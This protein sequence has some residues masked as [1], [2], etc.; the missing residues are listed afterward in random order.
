MHT[1]A[2]Q[3]K[4][5]KKH[6]IVLSF[7]LNSKGKLDVGV[8]KNRASMTPPRSRN[9]IP[10][11]SVGSKASSQQSSLR[12]VHREGEAQIPSSCLAKRTAIK[13]SQSGKSH[14]TESASVKKS[15]DCK[16]KQGFPCWLSLKPVAKLT[17]V[18]NRGSQK[19]NLLTTEKTT[20][21]Q[22]IIQKNDIKKNISSKLSNVLTE[23][24]MQ[25]RKRINQDREDATFA[26]SSKVPLAFTET[27]R[28]R[29]KRLAT[30]REDAA[31]AFSKTPKIQTQR[32][33]NIK[34]N[35]TSKEKV[36][37]KKI[38]QK[39]AGQFPFLLNKSFSACTDQKKEVVAKVISGRAKTNKKP[40]LAK[41]ISP[42]PALL[43]GNSNQK[44]GEKQIKNNSLTVLKN[45]P[46]SQDG[47]KNHL[48]LAFKKVG[49]VA[50]NICSWKKNDHQVT[51][52][53]NR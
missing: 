30:N 19:R 43:S 9:R 16:D 35:T 14:A 45:A 39:T 4:Y 23:T 5:I 13:P 51:N 47:I 20:D 8:K 25:K 15:H 21:E 48:M 6:H 28:Q 22:K 29:Y 34:N 11:S 52:K 36:D 7:N 10:K 31:S 24:K 1:V 18:T 33:V 32:K 53:E 49:Q 3:K 44:V 41:S 37:P 50:R 40:F 42:S 2:K 17:G 27:F 38:T 12:L 26:F 46:E